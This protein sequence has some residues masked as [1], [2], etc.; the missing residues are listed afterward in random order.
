MMS[1][2]SVYR[3]FRRADGDAPSVR[4][5]VIVMV[6]AAMLITAICVIRVTR[7]HEVLRLGLQ[8]SKASERVRTLRE[9]RRQLELEHATLTSPDRIRGL[10][11]QLGMEPVAPDS[12]RI[13]MPRAGT[14]KVAAR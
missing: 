5:V 11:M 7:Q 12:I 6:I 14:G 2:A 3:I 13:V 10:A 9:V 8:L 1:P 4:L